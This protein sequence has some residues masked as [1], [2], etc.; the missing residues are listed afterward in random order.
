VISGVT[1]K[2]HFL[3]HALKVADLKMRMAKIGLES[4]TMLHKGEGRAWGLEADLFDYDSMTNEQ[5]MD[6]T[7]GRWPRR[8]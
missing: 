6:I 2:W 8:R 5:L 3:S 7:Q 1:W 4:L